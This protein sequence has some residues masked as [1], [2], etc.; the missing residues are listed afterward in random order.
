MNN[1]DRKFQ[2]NIDLDGN[3]LKNSKVGD[4]LNDDAPINKSYLDTRLSSLTIQFVTAEEYAELTPL[5]NVLYLIYDTE[6]E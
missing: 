5:N 4:P 1:T 3:Y 6:S 2:C